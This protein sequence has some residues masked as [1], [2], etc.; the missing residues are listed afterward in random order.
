M[1]NIKLTILT[2]TFNRGYILDKLY[3]SLANQSLILFEWIIIDDGS[4][5]NTEQLV[6]E[7]IE[8]KPKFEIRYYR[9]KNG[10]KHRALNFGITKVHYDFV[11]IIDSDDY[12]TNSAVEKIYSWISSIEDD[13]TIAG[14][15]GLRG[16]ENGEPIGEFPSDKEFIDATNLERKKYKLLGDKAEIYRTN[17]LKKNKFPEFENE[18][19]LSEAAVWDAIAAKGYKLRWYGEIIC[20]CEYLEDGLTKNL[21]EDKIL[22]NFKGYTFVEKINISHRKFPENYLAIGRYYIRSRKLNKSITE[23]KNDID[24]NLFKIF[25]GSLLYLVR[26][27]IRQVTKI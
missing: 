1:N 6:K 27:K 7:W 19:F 3:K 13:D 23:I 12:M 17:I 9:Q 20:I 15:S 14:I 11:Y 22:K 24:V 4:T 8:E 21:D 25:Q 26:E 18:F 10:G 2:P 16:K 5:D